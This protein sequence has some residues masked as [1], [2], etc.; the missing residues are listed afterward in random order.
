MVESDQ[1]TFTFDAFVESTDFTPLESPVIFYLHR[2]YPRNP[3]KIT[4]IRDERMAVLEEVSSY[5][6]YTI[7]AQ[8]KTARG[9]WIG[10]ELDLGMA[11]DLPQHFL[12][13]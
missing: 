1:D 10:L 12:D 3:I 8:V 4:K 5:G 11:L 2:T 7:G 13:R 6:D 9:K